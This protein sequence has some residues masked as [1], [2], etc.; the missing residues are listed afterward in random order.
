MFDGLGDLGITVQNLIDNPALLV[1]GN[2]DFLG[3]GDGDIFHA[4]AGA[5]LVSGGGGVDL[6]F[7]DDGDDII[8]GGVGG[9]TIDGGAGFRSRQL[10]AIRHGA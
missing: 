1:S 9:D 5:D 6:L 2:D 10:C 4:G 7:G 3:S 8:A